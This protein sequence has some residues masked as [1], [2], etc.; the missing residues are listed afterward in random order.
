M[1]LRDHIGT[2]LLS[3]LGLKPWQAMVLQDRARRP[4]ELH[5]YVIDP[6]VDPRSF[7]SIQEWRSMKVVVERGAEP[8]LH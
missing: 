2:E 6:A 3:F 8:R 4:T 7:S 5:V 1:A